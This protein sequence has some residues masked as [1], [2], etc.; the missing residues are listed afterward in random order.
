MDVP[1]VIDSSDKLLIY[2][3]ARHNHPYQSVEMHMILQFGL[4]PLCMFTPFDSTPW[5]T[6]LQRVRYNMHHVTRCALVSVYDV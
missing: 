3:K 2:I 4:L 6:S 5:E 1:I